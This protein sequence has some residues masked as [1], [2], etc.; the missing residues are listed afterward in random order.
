MLVP[1]NLHSKFNSFPPPDHLMP[2][3]PIEPEILF[4]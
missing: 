1:K 4:T 2:K 3:I